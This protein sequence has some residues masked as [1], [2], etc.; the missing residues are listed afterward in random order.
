MGYFLVQYVIFSQKMK[1]DGSICGEKRY[2]QSRITFGRTGT[3]VIMFCL[4]RYIYVDLVI[5]WV[6]FGETRSS[7]IIL[8]LSAYKLEFT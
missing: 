3:M 4:F 6:S 1:I 2:C 7:I 8:E 5:N